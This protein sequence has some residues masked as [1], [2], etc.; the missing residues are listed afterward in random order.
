M[1]TLFF[2][3]VTGLSLIIL[4]F[5]TMAVAIWVLSGISALVIEGPR[6]IRALKD[7]LIKK[8]KS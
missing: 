6:I 1:E 7:K 2:G 4:M 8:L 3:V 5:L